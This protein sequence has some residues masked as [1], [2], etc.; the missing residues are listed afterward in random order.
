MGQE[1][2]DKKVRLKAQATQSLQ[3][4]LA[5]TAETAAGI[6]GAH[7]PSAIAEA[8][9]AVIPSTIGGLKAIGAW[10][11]AHLFTLSFYFGR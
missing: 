6:T 1:R 3:S 4:T 9:P 8:L 2:S 7:L 11:D 10:A 5:D